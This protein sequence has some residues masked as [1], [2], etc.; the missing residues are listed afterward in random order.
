MRVGILEKLPILHTKSAI[1]AFLLRVR[2]YANEALMSLPVG[3]NLC[4]MENFQYFEY[5]DLIYSAL[6]SDNRAKSWH[7]VGTDKTYLQ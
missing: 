7:L 4:G 3:K 6:L 1:F 2:S 5:L